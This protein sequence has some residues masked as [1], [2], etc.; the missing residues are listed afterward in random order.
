MPLIFAMINEKHSGKRNIK[1]ELICPL[2][3]GTKMLTG[4]THLWLFLRMLKIHVD[5]LV[6]KI[7]SQKHTLSK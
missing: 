2:S 4:N 3:T 5:G 7:S 6:T 1:E